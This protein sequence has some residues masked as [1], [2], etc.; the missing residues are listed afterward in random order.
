MTVESKHAIAFVFDF[1]WFSHRLQNRRSN[2]VGLTSK[3]C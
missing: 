2:G 1:S 3:S